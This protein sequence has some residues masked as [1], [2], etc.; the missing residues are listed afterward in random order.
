[1]SLG[2]SEFEH[3]RPYR[4]VR[5]ATPQILKDRADVVHGLTRARV[6]SHKEGGGTDFLPGGCKHSLF[7]HLIGVSFGVPSLNGRG[8]R[9]IGSAD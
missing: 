1:M 4:G 9:G 2:S 5:Y 6:Q 8:S 7:S 3:S